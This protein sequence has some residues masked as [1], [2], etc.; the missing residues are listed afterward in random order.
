MRTKDFINQ[1]REVSV[2]RKA[3]ARMLGRPLCDV[4]GAERLSV[5][6]PD[7]WLG[8]LQ[9]VLNAR[10]AAIQEARR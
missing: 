6:V 1:R 2:S 7:E 10:S 5:E 9:M 8:I 4:A 3:F